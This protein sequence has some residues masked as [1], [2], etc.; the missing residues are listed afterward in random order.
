MIINGQEY[1]CEQTS[2]DY[3]TTYRMYGDAGLFA[4]FLVILSLTAVG[5]WS[6]IVAVA[7]SL[8]GIIATVLLGILHLSWGPFIALVI[9]GILTIYRLNR[10]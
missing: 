7:L 10:K 9:T 4:S 3:D 5:V 8:V 6:P 2:Y 1:S